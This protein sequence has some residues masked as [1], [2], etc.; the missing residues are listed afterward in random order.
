VLTRPGNRWVTCW[1]N[2][3][4]ASGSLNVS[5][6]GPSATVRFNHHVGGRGVLVA[7]KLLTSSQLRL[8]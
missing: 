1:F 2:Q 8:Q 6:G 4:F 3:V 7:A 5:W